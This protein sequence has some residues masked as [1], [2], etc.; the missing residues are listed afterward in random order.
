MADET[1]DWKQQ[2]GP[3]AEKKIA[4]VK[5]MFSP[6]MKAAADLGI[7]PSWVLAQTALESGYGESELAKKYGN[8][9]GVKAKAGEAQVKMATT[10]GENNAPAVEPF[11]TYEGP[12][13]FFE[14]WTKKL[15][16]PR[17]SGALSATN[18]A[19]YATGLK[20]GGY[21]TGGLQPYTT[22]LQRIS[23][24]MDMILK[25]VPIL[26]SDVID[27]RMGQTGER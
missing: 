5:K 4:Y 3:Q 6:A 2:L 27:S 11:K 24:D 17:Y 7:D 14:D 10:E 9:G 21:F 19:G 16:M 20:Q 23:K 8:L 25:K 26:D 1:Q 12:N 22:N 13:Q 18:V 15:K